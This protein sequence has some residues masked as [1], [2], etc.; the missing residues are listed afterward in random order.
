[1]SVWGPVTA[2][3]GLVV[4][5]EILVLDQPVIVGGR[6]N[7]KVV[8][9]AVAGILAG[10]GLSLMALALPRTAQLLS[11]TMLVGVIFVRVDPR[12]P[13]PAESILAWYDATP[14]AGTP[15]K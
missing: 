7:P 10:G 8:R 14:P 13:S 15:V 2:G 11:W 6:W 3:V 9:T 4:A 12:T 1:M 5:N